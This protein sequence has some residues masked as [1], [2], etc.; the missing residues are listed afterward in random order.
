VK[1]IKQCDKGKAP[2]PSCLGA[3][4]LRVLAKDRDC[5]TGIC[6]MITDIINGDLSPE[7]VDI[8]GAATSVAIDK[9]GDSVRPLAVPEILYKI[10]SMYVHRS[11]DHIIPRLFPSI[12][13]GC[14]V[15]N[16][17]EIALIRT[18]LALE[19]GRHRDGGANTIVLSLDFRNAFNERKRTL[20]AKALFSAPETSRLWRFFMTFYGNSHSHLGV[21]SRGE[22]IFEFLNS[23][24]VKQ[25]DPSAS[26]FYALS[27]QELYEQTKAGDPLLEC[28]AIADDFTITG[29]SPNVILALRRLID[30]TRDEGP[31][32][33]PKKCKVLWA[34]PTSH[35]SYPA[36][37]DAMTEF[38]IP[39]HYNSIPLLGSSVGLGKHRTTHCLT[40]VDKHLPFF[41]ALRHEDMP[42]QIA[43]LLV[44][45]WLTSLLLPHSCHATGSHPVSSGE[46]R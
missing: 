15:K 18:Q 32:L 40:A 46:V 44:R 43:M 35:P 22:L 24:G 31:V 37:I 27:V 36:F 39:V 33:N 2:G 8:I 14:G 25:G 13:L 4:H 16:G 20:I 19:L 17:P 42:A 5:L 6:A 23:C 28:V 11:V 12:Q 45:V 38:G 10:A 3:A 41:A 26:L 7:A 9:G 29:P 21:Y 30:L 1:L 34:Y